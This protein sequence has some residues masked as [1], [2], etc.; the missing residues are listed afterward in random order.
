[1]VEASV[2]IAVGIG[3][4]ISEDVLDSILALQIVVAWAGEGGV[5]RI[6]WI[7]GVPTW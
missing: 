1:M 4:R 5:S 6:G 3:V 2:P 7:G